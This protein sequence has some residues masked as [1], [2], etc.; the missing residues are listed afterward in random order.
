MDSQC[1]KLQEPSV[2]DR[3]RKG[4]ATSMIP[5]VQ[6]SSQLTWA[7]QMSSNVIGDLGEDLTV[8]QFVM[9]YLADAVHPSGGETKIPG[10]Q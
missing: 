2:K 9:E 4:R 7:K 3:T 6:V 5:T 1:S 10:Q 8:I